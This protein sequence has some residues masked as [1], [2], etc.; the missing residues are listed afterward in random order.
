MALWGAGATFARVPIGMR[1]VAVA[2]WDVRALQAK[3]VVD[4][5]RP[6][7]RDERWGRALRVV[8]CARGAV[9]GAAVHALALRAAAWVLELN[10]RVCRGGGR[11]RQAYT[12]KKE[13]EGQPVA[14]ETQAARE[15]LEVSLEL[16]MH[17]ARAEFER[18]KRCERAGFR[19]PH[20]LTAQGWSARSWLVGA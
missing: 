8:S 17:K 5:A 9:P 3:V 10:R 19:P 20:T 4:G 14:P 6:V 12:L 7:G 15:A 11:R 13:L 18:R 2:G 1:V 16:I